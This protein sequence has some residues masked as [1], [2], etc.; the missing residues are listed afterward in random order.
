MPTAPSPTVGLA[1]IAGLAAAVAQFAGA[2]VLV[3]HDRTPESIAAFGTAA[4]TLVTVLIGR[5]WQAA[6]AAA[7]APVI[8]TPA[9][10]AVGE[11]VSSVG[12]TDDQGDER[13][14]EPDDVIDD[15]VVG[16]AEADPGSIPADGDNGVLGGEEVT[17]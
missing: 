6:K 5:Y 13:E 14:P 9:P 12:F 15:R 16:Y 11:L 7:P 2:A 1:T 8:V 17:R 10:A 3:A 4:G